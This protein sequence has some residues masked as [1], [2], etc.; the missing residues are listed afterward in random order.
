MICEFP[1]QEKRRFDVPKNFSV[2]GGILSHALIT[3]MTTSGKSTL[4]KEVCSQYRARGVKTIVLDPI[5]DRS[6]FE[7]ADYCT[8][9]SDDFLDVVLSS[10]RCA[11]FVDEAGDSIGQYNREMFVLATKARHKGHRSHFITQYPQQI[12]PTVRGQ[13]EHLYAF[14]L[15]NDAAKCLS[16]DW[17]KP[18]ILTCSDLDKGHYIYAPKF[19]PVRR[20]KVFWAA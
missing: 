4:A 15:N 17:N 5:R 20:G 2:G 16:K 6:W 11:V 13:C 12:A 7:L 8:S 18:D 14:A 19:G 3:G 1:T 10:E 9:Y